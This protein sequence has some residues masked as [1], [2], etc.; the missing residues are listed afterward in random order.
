MYFSQTDSSICLISSSYTQTHTNTPQCFAPLHSN[1]A[2][3][4]RLETL[5]DTRILTGM[6][7]KTR[8]LNLFFYFFFPF[9]LGNG[10]LLYNL[11]SHSHIS[12]PVNTFQRRNFSLIIST[13]S[14]SSEAGSF[15]PAAAPGRVLDNN[16]KDGAAHPHPEHQ[17]GSLH[18]MPAASPSSD[19]N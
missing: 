10:Y 11:L 16:R 3:I 17:R 1:E 7:E 14:S 4:G 12:F 6:P 18:L 9:L 2:E 19:L 15:P 13:R 8:N 5:H